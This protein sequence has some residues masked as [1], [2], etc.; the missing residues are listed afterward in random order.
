MTEQT[1]VQPATMEERIAVLFERMTADY[2]LWCDHR[3][4]IHAKHIG[5]GY[6]QAD[7]DQGVKEYRESLTYTAGK[8]YIRIIRKSAH[9]NQCE[10]FIVATNQH[11]KFKYGDML[12]AD[13]YTKPALNFSRGNIFTDAYTVKWTGIG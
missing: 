7:A 11:K 2:R 5:G 12:K 6:T 1:N 9:C 3:V 10:G 13:G 4:A 8:Q